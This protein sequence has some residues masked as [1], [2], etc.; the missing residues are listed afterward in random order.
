MTP[1]TYQISKRHRLLWATMTLLA[2]FDSTGPLG[3]TDR[4]R[5]EKAVS[6]RYTL[7]EH[8]MADRLK[9]YFREEREQ[10]VNAL[11][12]GQKDLAPLIVEMEADLQETLE[13]MYYDVAQNWGA[14]TRRHMP[15][16]K[17]RRRKDPGRLM[18]EPLKD[19]LRRYSSAKVKDISQ[20]TRQRLMRHLAEG[21]EAGETVQQ[22]AKRID[23]L[24]LDQ[25]IPN[26]SLTIA[27]TE[28]VNAAN[29]AGHKA[30]ADTGEP[31]EKEWQTNKDGRERDSHRSA[32]GQRVPLDQPF[33]VGGFKM[34][35]PGDGTLG[36]PAD[37]IVNCRCAQLF[38]VL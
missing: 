36:A 35:W 8:R 11:E 22:M 27:R 4:A 37:E 23:D 15:I 29:W 6:R 7:L 25:I 26:R 5:L 38:H 16:R 14:W 10:V 20:T 9:G 30:A 13:S 32:D 24:Y 12:Q 33:T 17:A 28:T 3:V 19:Y 1:E 2:D 18:Q 21:T 34:M 31:M